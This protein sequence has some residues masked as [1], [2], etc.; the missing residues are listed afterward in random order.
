MQSASLALLSDQ[1]ALQRALDVVANN[2]ANASTTGYKREG[3]EF[4]TLL[5]KGKDNQSIKFVIDRA[6]YRDNSTGPIQ[7]TNNPLD[8][9]I[10]GQ[11][12]FPVRAAD[13]TTEY[14]RSGAFQINTQGQIVT[15]S[16]LPVLGDG[17]Q[18]ITI[19]DTTTEMNISGDGF[20]T[21]RT[22][23]GTALSELGKIGVVKFDK[24]Q[25]LQ[26][27]G[28]GLYTTQQVS[29]PAIGSAIVQ[30]GLEQSNVEP[31]TEMTEMIR[32]SRAYEQT[33]NLIGQENSRRDDAINKLAKTTV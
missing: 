29:A 13:G 4:N 12:Y 10:Q 20:V 17:G 18:P 5:G 9:A 16:G 8:L 19:P 30:G 27:Q 2:V 15:L 32:I 28:G 22:D 21:A 11:G 14:T 3:I 1:Q 25:E 33:T 6:T 7:T 26:A 23:N 31:I 24:D